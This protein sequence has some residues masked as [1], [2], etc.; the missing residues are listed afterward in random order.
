MSIFI[1]DDISDLYLK[2]LNDK[3]I[4]IIFNKNDEIISQGKFV[5]NLYLIEDGYVKLSMISDVGRCISLVL[6]NVIL[7][8]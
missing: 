4:K 8:R 1:E 6:W 2:M 5:D 7:V 3:G